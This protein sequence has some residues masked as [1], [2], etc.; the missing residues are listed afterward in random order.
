MKSDS[1]SEYAHMRCDTPFP[2]THLYTFWMTLL[3]FLQLRTYLIDCLFPN[4]KTN[5]NI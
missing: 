1:V 5:K 3:S 2:C 4:Q